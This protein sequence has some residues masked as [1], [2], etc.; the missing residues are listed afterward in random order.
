MGEPWKDSDGDG[1]PDW[2][3]RKYGLDP[4]D[5]SDAARDCNGD[6]YTNIEKYLNGL[7]PK[8]KVDWQDLRNNRD[9][10]M[11]AP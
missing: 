4:N 6:G 3:E 8:Q 5:P 11:T 1:I 10:R 7:D 2:W 9:P